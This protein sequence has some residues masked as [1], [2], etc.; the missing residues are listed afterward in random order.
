MFEF[1]NFE[2]TTEDLAYEEF[3]SSDGTRVIA[4]MCVEKD[5]DG[6]ILNGYSYVFCN[7]IPAQGIRSFAQAVKTAKEAVE[8]IDKGLGLP[9]IFREA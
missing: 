4:G 5:R 3:F 8:R 7:G 2:F 6:K 9:D 1:M